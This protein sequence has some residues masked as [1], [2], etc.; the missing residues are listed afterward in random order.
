MTAAAWLLVLAAAA[1]APAVSVAVHPGKTEVPLAEAFDVEVRAQ[2]PEGTQWTFPPELATEDAELKIVPAA[3][4]AQ[5][6]PSDLAH[7]RAAVFVL[8]DAKLPPVVVKYRLPDG[9]TGEVASEPV[10]L[11]VTSVLPKNPDERKLADIRGPVSLS[12]GRAFWLALAASVLLVAGAVYAWWRRR[13]PAA[14]QRPRAPELPPAAEARAALAALQAEGLVARGAYRDYY[15]RLLEIA[16][17]YLER[18]LGAPVLEMTSAETSALLRS[19]IHGN[20]LVP[21][22]R[23]L[24]ATADRV[25]FAREDAIAAEAER[26]FQAAAALVDR[27][28]QRLQP[29]EAAAAAKKEVA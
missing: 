8:D 7:Y 11:R 6:P 9:T 28:E 16:K 1:P 18:R 23:E 22:V 15:I 29:I 25:K 2:G 19:H 3:P 14:A 20:E 21:T 10:P 4:G 24:M 27:L 5:A 12:I 17:R 13:R 26:H